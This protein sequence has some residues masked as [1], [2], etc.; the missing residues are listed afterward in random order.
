MPSTDQPCDSCAHSLRCK[1]EQLACRAFSAWVEAGRTLEGATC[2]PNREAFVELFLFDDPGER[3]RV[4]RDRETRARRAAKL[5]ALRQQA[6]RE[7]FERRRLVAAGLAQ[8][9]TKAERRKLF[10]KRR[11]MRWNIDPSLR[12][13]H[14]Q[15][16]REDAIR[17]GRRRGAAPAG[18][19]GNR[20]HRIEAQKRRRQAERARDGRTMTGPQF[21]QLRLQAGLT[22]WDIAHEL[23]VTYGTAKQ[24]Q[25]PN[26]FPSARAVRWIA[27]VTAGEIDPIRGRTARGIA[28]KVP[29]SPGSFST[30]A[31][32]AASGYLEAQP[33]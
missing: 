2:D 22:V 26:G 14:L 1:H 21:R 24:W 30:Q 7:A 18:S 23:G 11:R 25:K 27:A 19:E 6:R 32:P 15:L 10:L 20:R 4:Q 9:L 13:R 17:R 5:E 29:A 33:L 16:K 8:P 28:A 3:Y 31:T 12:E